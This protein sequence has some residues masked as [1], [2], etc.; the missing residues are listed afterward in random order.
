MWQ[1]FIASN[2]YVC[3][4]VTLPVFLTIRSPPQYRTFFNF[5]DYKFPNTY[6][7]GHFSFYNTVEYLIRTSENKDINT[8]E[9]KFINCVSSRPIHVLKLAKSTVPIVEHYTAF[10]TSHLLKLWSVILINS[11]LESYNIKYRHK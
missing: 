11:L 9:N 10:P 4:S 1:D 3:I 8:L 6:I 5:I 2:H 7:T